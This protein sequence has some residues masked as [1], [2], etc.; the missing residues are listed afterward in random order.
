MR[1]VVTGAAGFISG[2]GFGRR[3]DSFAAHTA[4]DEKANSDD[5]DCK[6]G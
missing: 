6:A 1:A 2:L 3:L 4:P 5:D